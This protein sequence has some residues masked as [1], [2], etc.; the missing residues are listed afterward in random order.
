MKL[1]LKIIPIFILV[2]PLVGCNSPVQPEEVISL[3]SET[4][5][6]YIDSLDEKGSA[7]LKTYHHKKFGEIPYV[8][9]DEYCDTFPKTSIKTSKL[10]EIIDEK[11]IVS[12]NPLGSYSFDASKDIVKTSKDVLYFFKDK[13]NVNNLIPYDVYTANDF[14]RFTKGSPLTQ[15]LTYGEERT[16][17]CKKYNFDIVYE[18]GYYYAPFS[19][20]N[21]LFFEF[22]NETYLYNGKD[23][24]DADSLSGENSLVQHCYSSNGNFLLDLSGGKLGASLY[25]NKTPVGDEEYHF[26]TEIKASGQK[27]VFSLKNGGGFIESYDKDGKIIEEDTFKKVKYERNGNYLNMRYFTVMDKEDDESQ[28]ISDVYKITIHMDETWFG[29]KTRSK[30][31]A[32]FTYQQLRFAMYE[33]YGD[34]INTAVKDFD[35]FIKDKSYKDDL[36]SLDISKY[37]AAM[38]EFLL[39]G[40]DDGHTSIEYTSLY[41]LPT[42]ANANHY[43]SLYSGPRADSITPLALKLRE[44]RKNAGL[45]QGLDIVDKTAFISFDKFKLDRDEKNV[46]KLKAYKEYADTDPKDYVESS[47]MEFFASCFN[48]IEKN[49]SVKNVVIDL[50]SNTGGATATMAYLLSYL[51]NDPHITCARLLN[52][53]IVEYHYRTDLDQDGVYGSSKDTFKDKY[54]FF[55]LIS[56]ASFSCGNH[57]PT[58]CKDNGIATIIGDKSAGGSCTLSYISNMSGYLYYSSSENVALMEQGNGYTHNDGGVTPDISIPRVDW[59]N[60]SKLNELLNNLK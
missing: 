45:S 30:E 51:S 25:E 43:A 4:S 38:S 52:N 36:L 55:V 37:D 26:E 28:A 2:S 16:Y 24:F 1:T 34:T 21:S 54:K 53:S 58:V 12:C 8:R 6:M 23:Y 50:S 31:V 32:D 10:Y 41:G 44:E 7:P 49:S 14:E 29:K 47:T 9:L 39:R 19:L 60:H 46:V 3:F 33:L 18:K 59:Y 35:T 22:G 15:Y 11:F 40:I 48:Q 57:F 56:N 20:L 27:F 17:D 5:R 42:F 13:R